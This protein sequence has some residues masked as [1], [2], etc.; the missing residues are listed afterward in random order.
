M[1]T[2]EKTGTGVAGSV[3]TSS[4]LYTT[5]GAIKTTLE[6]V[7]TSFADLDIA[8]ALAAACRGIDNACE[9]RF[10]LD[11][12]NTSVRYYT[13]VGAASLAIDD[14]VD[15][16]GVAVDIAGDGTFEQTWVTNIDY[17]LEPLNAA[18]DGWPWTRLRVHP[19][20][21]RYLPAGIPRSVKV[22]GRF[23]WATV[24]DQI[25]EATT[26]LAARLLQRVRSAP[27]GVVSVGIDAGA[28]MRIARMD[29]DVVFLIGPYSKHGI[30]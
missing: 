18:A 25:V 11:G 19:R 20:T 23:G 12:D 2:Y 17:T 27:F 28:A 1:T 24:P 3:A 4:D 26:I 6:L 7:G 13:P 30:Q 22:T 15:V 10:W 21:T 8:K 16:Q 9:R 29:P 14:A 5:A